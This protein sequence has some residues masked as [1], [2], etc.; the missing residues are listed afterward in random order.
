MKHIDDLNHELEKAEV[1]FEHKIAA[2]PKDLVGY[3]YWR[4]VGEANEQYVYDYRKIVSKFVDQIR[5]IKLTDF[6]KKRGL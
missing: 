3:D 1:F 5:P 6:M 2:I 4:L